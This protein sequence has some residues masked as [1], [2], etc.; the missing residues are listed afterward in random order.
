M[1]TFNEYLQEKQNI[2]N[3]RELEDSA[4]AFYWKA[5]EREINHQDSSVFI[6]NHFGRIA[7]QI[8][9]TDSETVQDALINCVLFRLIYGL[10][11]LQCKYQVNQAHSESE[12]QLERI[13]QYAVTLYRYD[14]KALRKSLVAA[15][16]R[17][18]GTTHITETA[19]RTLHAVKTANEQTLVQIATSLLGGANA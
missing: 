15:F 19:S 12:K 5:L 8:K 18:S 6:K 1:P 10:A 14:L 4:N 13:G 2:K 11:E 9:M 3:T 7:N 16:N 17:A